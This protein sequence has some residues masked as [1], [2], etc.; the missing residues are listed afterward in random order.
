MNTKQAIDFLKNEINCDNYEAI[1]N[2]INILQEGTDTLTYKKLK[3]FLRETYD[4]HDPEV[5][6]SYNVGYLDCLADNTDFF[7]YNQ[8][9]YLIEV[10]TE[11]KKEKLGVSKNRQEIKRHSYILYDDS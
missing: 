8:L 4:Y 6:W 2:I 11:M 7:K 9:S 3:R 5:A 1:E 10:N